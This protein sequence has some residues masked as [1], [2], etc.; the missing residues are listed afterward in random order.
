MTYLSFRK[1]LEESYRTM[2]KQMEDSLRES[3]KVVNKGEDW[4]QNGQRMW[5]SEKEAFQENYV[6]KSQ[7]EVEAVITA[8]RNARKTANQVRNYS[9]PSLVINTP[10]FLALVLRKDKSVS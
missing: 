8:L 10:L 6:R 4:F 3:S 2:A 1:Q 7:R 5:E 9:C